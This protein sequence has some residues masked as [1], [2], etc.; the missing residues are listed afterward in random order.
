MKWLGG[1]T[2]TT[3]LYIEGEWNPVLLPDEMDGAFSMMDTRTCS[4]WKRHLQAERYKK[5]IAC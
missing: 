4:R 5:Q 1:P 2:L 3:I